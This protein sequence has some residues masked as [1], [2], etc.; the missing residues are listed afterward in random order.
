ME[1]YISGEDFNNFLH[2]SRN[3]LEAKLLNSKLS[4]IRYESTNPMPDFVKN[5]IKNLKFL[6]CE[7]KILWN[8][9]NYGIYRGLTLG[10]CLFSDYKIIIEKWNNSGSEYKLIQNYKIS[11]VKG[12][13]SP[14][15]IEYI[16]GLVQNNIRIAQLLDLINK[17]LVEECN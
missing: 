2:N 12:I 4:E 9:D 11:F 13:I 8:K 7:N 5:I 15:K 1:Y 17:K 16:T 6:T 10:E 14:V 3:K